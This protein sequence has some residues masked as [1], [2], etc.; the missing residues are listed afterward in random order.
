MTTPLVLLVDDDPGM[1]EMLGLILRQYDCELLVAYDGAAALDIL[2]QRTP[3]VLVLDLA[4]PKLSGRR[5]LEYVR[6]D[7][8]LADIKV[9]V[10]TA[11]AHMFPE[12]EPLGID[13]WLIKPFIPQTLVDII[14]ECV[15]LSEK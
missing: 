14:K 8:R 3:D 5:V 11:R 12:I 10:L 2:Q 4:L 1:L 6:G 15:G 7:P 9:I 13:C